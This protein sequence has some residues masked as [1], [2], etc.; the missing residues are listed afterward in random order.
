MG[1]QKAFIPLSYT[2]KHDRA[3]RNDQNLIESVIKE[4]KKVP[5]VHIK[6]NVL[7]FASWYFFTSG[8]LLFYVLFCI[9]RSLAFILILNRELVDL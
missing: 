6:S 7:I 2:N 4:R 9:L 8:L 1:Q 5:S 3:W